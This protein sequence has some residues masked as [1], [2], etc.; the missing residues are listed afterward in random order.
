MGNRCDEC[1]LPIAEC[2]AL[3]D[4]RQAVENSLLRDG[5]KPL[6]ARNRARELIANERSEYSVRMGHQHAIDWKHVDRV[7][8][9][10]KGVIYTGENPFGGFKHPDESPIGRLLIHNGILKRV[11]AVERHAVFRPLSK[12]ERIGFML[13]VVQ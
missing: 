2:N 3:A 5:Y 4:A 7:E 1:G 13:E 8:I 9:A 11:I 6:E 10:G 12:G